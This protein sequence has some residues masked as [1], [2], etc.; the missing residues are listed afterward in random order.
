MGTFA[1]NSLFQLEALLVSARPP[2]VDG[3]V[4]P[5]EVWRHPGPFPV[6]LAIRGIRQHGRHFVHQFLGLLPLLRGH[7]QEDPLLSVCNASCPRAWYLR[8]GRALPSRVLQTQP[9]QEGCQT[10][11]SPPCLNLGGR[12]DTVVVHAW[13]IMFTP[14]KVEYH[15]VPLERVG[16]VMSAPVGKFL[17]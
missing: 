1:S 12:S 7:Q 11:G 17:G 3:K 15:S 9:A 4:Q 14:W 16:V 5:F 6:Q 10:P 2:P 8:W 13:L